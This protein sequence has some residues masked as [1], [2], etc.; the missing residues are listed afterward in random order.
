MAVS[1]SDVDNVVE[2]L[3]A[4]SRP[5]GLSFSVWTKHW[6]ANENRK[7]DNKLLHGGEWNLLLSEMS[8][9]VRIFAET[10]NNNFSLLLVKIHF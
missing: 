7:S 4:D 3:D 1:F 6:S 9:V 2:A 5:Y 10:Q 8:Y